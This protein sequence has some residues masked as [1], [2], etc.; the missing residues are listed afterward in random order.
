MSLDTK[1]K[2]YSAI[3]ILSPWRSATPF[4][5]GAITVNDRKEL[6]VLYSGAAPATSTAVEVGVGVG[7]ELDLS[8]QFSVGLGLGVG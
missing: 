6:A 4:P 1:D 5:N 2:R 3:Y 8:H 7:I